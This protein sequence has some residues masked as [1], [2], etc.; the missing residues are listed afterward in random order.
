MNTFSNMNKRLLFEVPTNRLL[1]E[2]EVEAVTYNKFFSIAVEVGE[3]LPPFDHSRYDVIEFDE[4]FMVNMNILNRIRL[5]C[6]VSTDKIRV[7]KGDTK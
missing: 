1:Q 2:K 4:I 5:F 6:L 3:R 7:G